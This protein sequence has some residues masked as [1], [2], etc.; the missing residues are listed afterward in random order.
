MKE[1]VFKNKY[2][3]RESPY[4]K[5]LGECMRLRRCKST[6][7]QGELSRKMGYA[8][9]QVSSIENGR[10]TPDLEYCFIFCLVMQL[11][12][13]DLFLEIEKENTFTRYGDEVNK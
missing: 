7:N 10:R 5:R 9:P 2:F 6:L 8:Q 13:S 1:R 11:K 12:M 4:H 3:F